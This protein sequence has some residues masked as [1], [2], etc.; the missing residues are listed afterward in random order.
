M[1]PKY[2]LTS[3]RFAANPLPVFEK[4]WADGTV[5][6]GR[7]PFLGKTWLVTR[8]DACAQVLKS[9]EL[10]VREGKN[11]DHKGPPAFTR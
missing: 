7:I 2:D 1:I 3:A 10:F 4:L 11:A 9:K 6:Q 8:H 5:V